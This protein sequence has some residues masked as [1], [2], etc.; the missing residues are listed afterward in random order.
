MQELSKTQAPLIWVL[1]RELPNPWYVLEG[2]GR[3]FIDAEGLLTF[4]RQF[5]DGP[6]DG[7]EVCEDYDICDADVVERIDYIKAALLEKI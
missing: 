4:Q 3:Y 1:S 5:A 2:G 7:P 6:R